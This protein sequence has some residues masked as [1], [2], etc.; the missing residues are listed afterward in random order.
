M[1]KV[2]QIKLLKQRLRRPPLLHMHTLR[3]KAKKLKLKGKVKVE[4]YTSY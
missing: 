3:I 4:T 1:I 2:K